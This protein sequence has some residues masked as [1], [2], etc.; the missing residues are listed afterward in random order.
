MP[1]TNQRLV[2]IASRRHSE[3]KPTREITG[4]QYRSTTRQHD[5][6]CAD[7]TSRLSKPNRSAPTTGTATRL[8]RR[9]HLG[10][11]LAHRASATD[12]QQRTV[13]A[14]QGSGKDWYRKPV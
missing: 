9:H 6:R 5:L 7:Q 11:R 13:V 8:Q 10:H 1:G 2:R 3:R 4:T 14:N 12:T